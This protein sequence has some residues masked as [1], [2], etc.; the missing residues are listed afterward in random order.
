MAAITNDNHGLRLIVR[1]AVLTLIA[2]IFVFPL[3]FM[4]MPVSRTPLVSPTAGNSNLAA[5][6]F[7]STG[8]TESGRRIGGMDSFIVTSLPLCFD[9]GRF[10]R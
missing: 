9:I 2:I 8:S 10:C 4:L 6:T 7:R 1:Y 5:N 3:V